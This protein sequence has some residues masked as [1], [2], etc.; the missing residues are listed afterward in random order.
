MTER[1]TWLLGAA[2]AT[3]VITVSTAAFVWNNRVDH[4]DDD[5]SPVAWS[6]TAA[7]V[8]GREFAVF[9]D[10]VAADFGYAGTTFID[11]GDTLVTEVGL[12]NHAT[13]ELEGAMMVGIDADNGSIRWRSPA[14][15]LGG[16][17]PLAV[18]DTVFCSA[19][20]Y[21]EEPGFVTIDV[22]SGDVER[23][24]TDL[25]VIAIGA[26]EDA[27]FVVEGN[28]EDGDLR[29]HAESPDD[30]SAEWTKNIDLSA[31]YEDFYGGQSMSI[32][33]GV[34]VLEIGG[35]AAGFDLDTG[36][37][38]WRQGL[39]ACSEVIR[40]SVGGLVTRVGLD[41][42]TYRVENTELIGTGGSVLA[43]ADSEAVHRLE[44]DAP[45]DADVS[46]LLG[47][48]GFDRLTG[49]RRW[50]SADLI[51]DPIDPTSGM[52]SPNST[53]GTAVAI[54]GDVA[55]L[56]DPVDGKESA[57]DLST[58][59]RLWERQIELV[60]QLAAGGGTT[61]LTAGGQDVRATDLR[62]GRP[63]WTVP[64]ESFDPGGDSFD[65]SHTLRRAGD[66]VI[67]LSENAIA[68]FD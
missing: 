2:T 27:V 37:L 50:T 46:V 44:L 20:N 64:I 11:A 3:A 16:C 61:L 42:S 33:N 32:A 17:A 43:T 13:D 30:P 31:S 8:Y 54:V 10:P 25:S 36:E 48:G 28:P 4:R 57:L 52:T 1:S 12:R 5:G 47:D 62:T 9:L 56:R 63:V 15:E 53:F 49:E 68:A 60:G 51:S 39:P 59:Q 14:G 23:T 58:G 34:G 55:L 22:D 21:S 24:P 6:V 45:A 38:T 40:P 41:C 66:R 65:S 26:S 7:E 35:E 18:S 29:L 19:G 67:Y